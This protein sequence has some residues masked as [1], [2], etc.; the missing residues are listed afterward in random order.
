[1]NM[2]IAQITYI[3]YDTYIVFFNKVSVSYIPNEKT[4]VKYRQTNISLCVVRKMI[5]MNLYVACQK[6]KMIYANLTLT[7][8]SRSNSI[9]C[10]A[11]PS[12]LLF[13]CSISFS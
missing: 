4:K 8:L 7:S 5:V 9:V 2:V 1:M 13:A 12:P 6:K 3:T 10:I 11:S